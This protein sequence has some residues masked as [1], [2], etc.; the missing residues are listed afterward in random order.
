MFNYAICKLGIII[1]NDIINEGKISTV[2]LSKCTTFLKI[3]AIILTYEL[4]KHTFYFVER[5]ITG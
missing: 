3:G 1:L 2:W 5:L 4:I